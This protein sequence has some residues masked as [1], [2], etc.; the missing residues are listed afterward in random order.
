MTCGRQALSCSCR[1][2]CSVGTCYWTYR[3]PC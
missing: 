1:G 3:W 2:V